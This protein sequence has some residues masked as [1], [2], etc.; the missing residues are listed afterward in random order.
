MLIKQS[1]I[2]LITL[3]S[4]SLSILRVQLKAVPHSIKRSLKVPQHLAA[5]SQD[6]SNA[7]DV[8]TERIFNYNMLQYYGS[9]QIGSTK[10]TLTSI[11][12]TGS[13]ALWVAHPTSDYARNHVSFRCSES[14]TCEENEEYG[15]EIQY[16]SGKMMGLMA[17]DTLYFNGQVLNKYQ[18]LIALKTPGIHFKI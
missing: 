17:N 2:T 9:I 11:F 8:N 16:G 5:N 3:A 12:D 10:K 15:M 7:K 13:N 4:Y 14:T 1:L 6:S 18:F